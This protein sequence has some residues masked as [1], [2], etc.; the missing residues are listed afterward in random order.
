MNLLVASVTGCLHVHMARE[1][2]FVAVPVPPITQIPNE[3]PEGRVAVIN[4]SSELPPDV[5]GL[6]KLLIGL[7]QNLIPEAWLFVEVADE[8]E[9]GF[10]WLG[11]DQRLNTTKKSSARTS[12][13]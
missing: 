8:T 13:T 7:H 4:L 5:C 3:D 9:I 1:M 6:M 2:R 11:L 10:A 12:Q